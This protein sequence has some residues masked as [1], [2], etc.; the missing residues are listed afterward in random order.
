M[1]ISLQQ[2][3]QKPVPFQVAV[4][5]GDIDYLP[6]VTQ[7]ASLQADGM[8]QLLSHSVGDIR[9]TG[10]LEVLMSAVCDRCLESTAFPLK[11]SFDLV[12]V[13]AGES[14]AGEVEIDESAIEVGFYE[15][16]GI[17]VNEVLRE[18]ILLALPMQLTCGENCKGICLVCGQNRNQVDCQCEVKTPGGDD[19]W[20]GLRNLRSI[21]S[22]S[23]V[24]K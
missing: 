5:V 18:V 15:G 7:T 22:D 21:A 12:Y 19:R 16:N 8:V 2:L 4:P 11:N 24:V 1:F 3:E 14:G 23:Q 17:E 13:P 6:N 20:N 10:K 9:V